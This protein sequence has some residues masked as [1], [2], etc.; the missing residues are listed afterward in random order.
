MIETPSDTDVSFFE[1]FARIVRESGLSHAE[2]ARRANADLKKII[3][4]IP[5]TAERILAEMAL[6]KLRVHRATV[7][8]AVKGETSISEKMLARIAVG[9]DLDEET[10]RWL[11]EL[12]KAEPYV[13][14]STQQRAVIKGGKKNP[15]P[16][17][18]DDEQPI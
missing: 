15:F 16:S 4:A 14:H 8:R 12:R 11:E 18:F 6:Q 7:G 10:T 1:A 13:H 5:D 3:D 17:W 9:L 2:I